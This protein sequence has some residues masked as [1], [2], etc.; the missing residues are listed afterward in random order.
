MCTEGQEREA[1]KKK[2]FKEIRRKLL[3]EK[4]LQAGH[5]DPHGV[6]YKPALQDFLRIHL[7]L[8]HKRCS[9]V[10][11]FFPVT[12][13]YLLFL[14]SPCTDYFVNINFLLFNIG[15]FQFTGCMAPH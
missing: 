6:L 4:K 3:G 14:A 2:Q 15:V 10:T 11:T 12:Y 1:I 7:Q 13:L 8:V 5:A 9:A